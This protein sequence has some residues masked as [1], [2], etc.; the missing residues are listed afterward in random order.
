LIYFKILLLAVNQYFCCIC[1]RNLP[2]IFMPKSLLQV[3]CLLILLG[4]AP[5][6]HAQL[7][8]LLGAGIGAGIRL[9]HSAS[10]NPH[11]QKAELFVTPVTF[12]AHTFP[13]KRTPTKKVPKADKGGTE[14][15]AIEQL[16]SARYNALQA[17]S[18]SLLLDVAQE[19]EFS[20]LRTNLAAFNPEWSSDA[21][22]AEMD[23]Y[24]DH[25]ARR[26]RAAA[27]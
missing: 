13:Q 16:L 10:A 14:V 7:S 19:K 24:R 15:I 18:T 3:S 8:T 27:R 4:S 9:A 17:D 1:L 26:R 11:E 22:L 5:T 21:Y 23:F 25:D 2:L 6:A 12:Q 20:R